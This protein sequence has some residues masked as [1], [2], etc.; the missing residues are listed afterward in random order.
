MRSF[1]TSS[2]TCAST[3][4][5]RPLEELR[6]VYRLHDAL[7][8]RTPKEQWLDVDD[9]LRTDLTQRLVRLG[10]EGPL[11]QMLPAWAGTENYEMRV[12]G[13]ERV[14]PVVLE[15]LREMT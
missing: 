7:F 6:R 8:G 9:A 4:I 12:E 2:S 1:R 15:A 10:Y 3:T 13:V 5:A 14:D 11:E